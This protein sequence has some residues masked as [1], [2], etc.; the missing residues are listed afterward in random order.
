MNKIKMTMRTFV[1][2]L[3]C[4]TLVCGGCASTSGGSNMER[5]YTPVALY[6]NPLDQICPNEC[7]KYFPIFEN[8]PDDW[9][10]YGLKGAPFN[11]IN[12]FDDIK[13]HVKYS[14]QAEFNSRGQIVRTL[15]SAWNSGNEYN[16]DVD[17]KLTEIV[18]FDQGN[19]KKAYREQTSTF[20]YDE[21]RLE[22]WVGPDGYRDLFPGLDIKSY[23]YEY[24]PDST[25]MSVS[26]VCSGELSR[27]SKFGTYEFNE[28]GQL[29]RMT[30]PVSSNPFF[31]EF[32]PESF[33][34]KSEAEFQ[35]NL[36]GQCIVKSEKLI[37]TARR[38]GEVVTDTLP[39]TSHYQ[40]DENN[41]LKR[42]VYNGVTVKNDNS[43][44]VNTTMS[45]LTIDYDYLYDENGNWYVAWCIL[46]EDY[47]NYIALQ[48]WY[49]D[50]K[51][52][53][54]YLNDPEKYDGKRTIQF[55]RDI[56]GYYES[57][58]NVEGNGLKEYVDETTVEK[59]KYTGTMAY[60]LQGPVKMVKN[61]KEKQ[62]TVF[63]KIGNIESFISANGYR[64]CNN[65]YMYE[66]LIRYK[67]GDTPYRIDINGNV[68]RMI[69][70]PD[71]EIFEFEDE[72]EFDSQGRVIKHIWHDGMSPVTREFAY[73]G[74]SGLPYK[75]IESSFDEMGDWSKTIKYE[76]VN[77]DKHGNWTKRIGTTYSDSNEYV[78]IQNENG[79][80]EYNGGTKTYESVDTIVE[81]RKITYY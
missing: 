61:E 67:N 69:C 48:K 12:N 76:Y 26:P 5:L 27:K 40:Y 13:W 55:Q 59:P 21:T 35:Y 46:P 64:D 77:V 42:W 38:K 9:T 49:T 29:V 37:L 16:Y 11:V 23:R 17:G 73:Q 14:F 72:Y 65:T 80:W 54:P 75:E 56:S 41:N 18:K 79:E 32:T 6:F 81:T 20:K 53:S 3:L 24:F 70:E 31:K 71:E 19:Y 43:E 25:L 34:V 39:A 45:Q 68:M 74:D 36:Q 57:D 44:S 63:N 15:N 2:F 1:G 7:V 28:K 52:S 51:Q 58:D 60:G 50:N 10:K 78:D 22:S 62:I 47:E 4:A 66:S 8:Y 33:D 30:A